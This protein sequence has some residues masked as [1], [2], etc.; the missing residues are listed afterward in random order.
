MRLEYFQMIDRIVELDVGARAA[1][2][3][4]H[5]AAAEHRVRGPLSGLSADA[6][7]AADRMHGADHRLAGQRARRLRR[8]ADSGR[9]QGSQIPQRRSFP[10]TLLEFEG[11][12]QHEGSGYAI[13]ECAGRHDGKVVCEARFD[14]SHHAL[15]HAAIP[16][17]RCW[18]GR[19]GSTSRS[20]SSPSDGTPRGVD[21]RRRSSH[22]PGRGA[23]RGVASS[24]TRRSAALRRQELCAL[25]R[26]SAGA[27]RFRQ[28]DSEEERSAAD[29][30]VAARRRLCRRP[31]ARRRRHRRQ[32]RSARPHRHDRRRRR[33]RARRRRRYRDPQPACARRPSPAPSSTNG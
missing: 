26:A 33:R 28:A 7:R 20:R 15:S 19:S 5:R 4:L 18:I 22:L 10:A 6:G 3:G 27:D 32:A 25:H 23:R 12:V 30:A 24:R 14:L 8:H 2:R 29:G 17:G 31:R 11:H 13:G 1:A 21:H 9:R 16:P